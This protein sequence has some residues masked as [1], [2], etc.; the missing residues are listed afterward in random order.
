[1]VT[2][3]ETPGLLAPARR[4]VVS[5]GVLALL[6]ALVLS[7]CRGL[8]ALPPTDLSAPGWRVQQGQAVWKPTRNKLELAGELLLATN[9]NKSFLVQFTKT[10]F[11]LATAQ[12]SGESWQIEFG[13]GEYSRR[14]HGQPPARFVWF[15]LPRAMAGA[16]L[17]RDWKFK[18]R[19]NNSWRLENLRT[20]ESLEGAF[21][22]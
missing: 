16:E 18:Q 7:G 12:V 15:Q 4:N 6:S 11:P 5:R 8:P 22:Q 14:G 1:M 3:L 13:S 10:P 9:A 19:E 17:S 2:P 21:F 20:G